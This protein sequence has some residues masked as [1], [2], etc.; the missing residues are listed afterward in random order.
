[1]HRIDELKSDMSSPIH[2]LIRK[3]QNNTNNLISP[4]C[5]KSF[6]S[7]TAFQIETN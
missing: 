7:E 3:S 1:M 5:Q 2:L 6:N 4:D